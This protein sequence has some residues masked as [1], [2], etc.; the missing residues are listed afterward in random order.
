MVYSNLCLGCFNDKGDQK[1]CLY[2][3]Y[4]PDSSPGAGLYLIP[5][6]LLSG[7]S[8]WVSIKLAGV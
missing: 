7:K 8:V 4:A 5:G 3:V 1:P 2:C 6:T